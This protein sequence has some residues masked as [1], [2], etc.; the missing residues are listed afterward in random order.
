M[1]SQMRTMLR[2]WRA[3]SYDGALACALP[4]SRVERD[5]RSLERI[6]SSRGLGV[7]LLDLPTLDDIL[8]QL[9]EHGYAHFQGP[10]TARR[11]KS[12]SRPKFLWD[13]WNLIVDDAG[14]LL[15]NPSPDAIVAIRN[16]SKGLSKLEVQC[17]DARLEKSI[18]EFHDIE[19]S[20]IMPNESWADDEIILSSERMAQMVPALSLS[21]RYTNDFEGREREL[22]GFAR[23]F[24]KVAGILISQ[25]G[26]FDSLS[27]DSPENGFFKHGPG[28][29]S[30]QPGRKYKYLFPFWSDKLDRVF[31]FDWCSGSPLGTLPPDGEEKPGRLLA[32]PKTAKGPRLIASEP[33]EHQWCQ[34]K[35]SSWL[36][37]RYRETRVGKF[38]S[39]ENQTLS[40]RMV[41]S[42][43]LDRSLST[44]DLS[45]AS[46]R[47]A[48]WH[49][50]TLFRVNPDL[51][52]A[53]HAVRTRRIED[54]VLGKGISSLK[55]FTT[56]GSALTFPV[57]SIFFLVVAL[58][59]CGAATPED[60][61]RLR[62]K[63]RVFG[64]DI[65]IPTTAYANV[66]EC[67]SALGLKVNLKKSFF[68]GGFRESCGA[69]YW[70]G[71]NVT[72]VK[73]KTVTPDTAQ[74]VQAILDS[75]N[76]FHMRG[77]WRT[78][79]ALA[80]L[81]PR[82][83]KNGIVTKVDDHHPFLVNGKGS[84][85][86]ADSV[87]P[88]LHTFGEEKYPATRWNK[89]LQR[90]DTRITAL[91]AP[92]K[93]EKQDHSASL[94]E[95]FTRPWREFIPRETGVARNRVAILATRWVELQS[96][97]FKALLLPKVI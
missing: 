8:T 62:G 26:S 4:F 42:A 70:D 86:L 67:L 52:R 43:S 31:P 83:I 17:T 80:D 27:E 55:K 72:P 5:Q 6:A 36:A 2:I 59:A 47:V 28:A 37:S 61:D 95:F 64:D 25:L 3:M 50:E 65:I 51:I 14:V 13:F 21:S 81:L 66:T 93:K 16:L 92:V 30:N 76:N 38:I 34:Q 77:Y 96:M 12:D 79:Q 35:I 75:S 84:R 44:I 89:A 23:R 22:I 19:D 57:Q 7:F 45:S 9:L 56:M 60:I 88:A 24:D 87:V 20:I 90:W 1:K 73:P 54:G 11:S 91:H 78:A 40:Q 63:V 39:L 48:T 85:S 58:A 94:R 32:V 15:S 53:M 46:D 29:V 74:S 68:K 97:Q 41:A 49:I 69:D 33:I 71:W 82:T 10:L 18:Q